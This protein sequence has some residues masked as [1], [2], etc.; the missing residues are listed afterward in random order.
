MKSLKDKIAK[1]EDEHAEE[2]FNNHIE[3]HT[4]QERDKAL[5]LLGGL[6]A[7]D[8]LTQILSGE[9]MTALVTFEK[10]KMFESFGFTRFADFLEQWDHSPM[11]K[12]QFYD[13][14]KIFENEGE[15]L[16]DVLN[17]IGLPVQK[18]KLLG[19]GNVS[20]DGETV[21]VKSDDGSETSIEISDRARL[22]E[23]L[24]ALA[25]RSA[26]LNEQ[27]KKQKEKIERGEQEIEK[28]QKKLDEAKDRPGESSPHKIHYEDFMR[29]CNSVD[30]L[31]ATV[32]TL[33][34]DEAAGYGGLYFD[35]LDVAM[36]RLKATYKKV[37]LDVQPAPR[38]PLAEMDDS[39]IANHV[40]KKMKNFK[41]DDKDDTDEN[42]FASFTSDLNDEEL[43]GLMD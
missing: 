1:I 32:K 19:K 20:L 23:T 18:R 26:S 33:P 7:I 37:G 35:S 38:L 5:L 28:L 12:N 3:T 36:H 39:E 27:T 34:A 15:K 6:R 42:E 43:E 4:Q 21:I 30:A 9:V 29:A 14:K 2:T 13:R 41:G 16:F 8:C 17:G 25:D 24:T 31:A 10:E 11:T 22:L 40:A